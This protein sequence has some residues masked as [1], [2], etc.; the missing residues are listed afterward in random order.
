MPSKAR[1]V[2]NFQRATVHAAQV[3]RERRG[4]GDEAQAPSCGLAAQEIIGAAQHGA[5]YEHLRWLTQEGALFVSVSRL[6]M[7]T[8]GLMSFA[9][10]A[11]V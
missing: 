11:T 2:A 5:L 4:V 7:C 3:P 1:R 8:R 9:F 6:A 10:G